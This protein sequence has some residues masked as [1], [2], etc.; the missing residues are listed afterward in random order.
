MIIIITII[1]LLF[2]IFLSEVV[3]FPQAI[4]TMSEE[5]A[6]RSS[7]LLKKVPLLKSTALNRWMQ[8]GKRWKRSLLLL[9]FFL[10]FAPRYTGSLR[11]LNINYLECKISGM[12][13]FVCFL[14]GESA[15]ERHR[16]KP[17]NC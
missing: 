17:L 16:V 9:F 12:A 11:D 3:L 8:T 2:F 14:A 7:L 1:L 13:L 10:I 4:T 15:S 5:T 6:D